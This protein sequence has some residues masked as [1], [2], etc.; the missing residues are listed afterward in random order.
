MN[1]YFQAN[2]RISVLTKS[3]CCRLQMWE[4]TQSYKNP[5][6]HKH[7]LAFFS[8]LVPASCKLILQKPPGTFQQT[9]VGILNLR[10]PQLGAQ[11]DHLP[12]DKEKPNI[13]FTFIWIWPDC[14]RAQ[15]PRHWVLKAAKTTSQGFL[16]NHKF[17]L[18]SSFHLNIHSVFVH[19]YLK[20][21]ARLLMEQIQNLPRL[22]WSIIESL[23]E[24]FC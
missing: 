15:Y 23:E 10:E 17:S 20:L 18:D 12:W 19:F 24:V 9:F 22:F 14:E 8:M 2:F 13:S 11:P 1:K 7:P 6:H 4:A 21:S 5:S 3:L 16:S